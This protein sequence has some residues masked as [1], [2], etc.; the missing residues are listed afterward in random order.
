[1][2]TDKKGVHAHLMHEPLFLLLFLLPGRAERF[3]LHA[4]WHID[5][6]HNCDRGD[7]RPEIQRLCRAAS[8]GYG[9]RATGNIGKNA[10]QVILKRRPGACVHPVGVIE[11]VMKSAGRRGYPHF[12]KRCLT[13]DHDVVF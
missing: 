13:V 4:A 7:I 9:E 2:A 8:E 5:R 10:A 1:M 12:L 6:R 11:L 3:N